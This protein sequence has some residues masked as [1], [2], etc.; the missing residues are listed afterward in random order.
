VLDVF[1][2][3]GKVALVTGA[4][5]GLGRAM[6]E[7]LARAGAAVA[8]NSRKPEACQAAARE[9]AEK[10][11]RATLAAPCHVSEWDALAPML[12]RVYAHFGR[13]DVLVNNAGINPVPTPIERMTQ[14][15]WDKLQAVNVK[16]PLRLSQLAAPLMAKGG[17]GSII[18]VIS[19]GAYLGG[20]ATGAYAAGKA[21]LRSLTKVMAA[22]WAPI[23][24]RVNALAPG[25]FMTDM[26]RGAA[27]MPGYLEGA[28]N[29]SFQKRIAEPEEIAG[30]A[31][32]LASRA[33]SFVTGTVLTVAGGFA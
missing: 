24:V 17:G 4:T 26:M 7:G 23:G 31:V 18:Q 14:E 20:P 22:E 8:V 12:E 28:A 15:Y 29:L 25:S 1:D 21:A 16:G 5:R 33:S 13:L 11:G 27:Q 19:V 3:S 32:F 30:A 6:A 10:S 9:I 2:L